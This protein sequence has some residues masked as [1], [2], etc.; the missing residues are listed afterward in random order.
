[1]ARQHGELCAMLRGYC[2]TLRRPTKLM[3]TFLASLDKDVDTLRQASRH[4]VDQGDS[5]T[6]AEPASAGR[7]QTRVDMAT[8]AAPQGADWELQVIGLLKARN[9]QIDRFILESSGCERMENLKII[10]KLVEQRAR[11][12]RCRGGGRDDDES[13]RR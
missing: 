4:V 7:A 8:A 11:S 6:A 10:E 9:A 1:M 2:K 13:V 3:Q 12:C 5:S